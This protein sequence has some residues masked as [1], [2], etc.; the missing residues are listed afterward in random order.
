M[1]ASHKP[2]G[3][4]TSQRLIGLLALGLLAAGC[5]H[6]TQLPNLSAD[7]LMQRGMDAYARHKWT[8]AVEA[9]EQFTLQYPQN[10]RHQ[11]ARFRLAEAYIGKKEYITAATELGKLATDYPAGNYADDA[12]LKIC[13]AYYKM[14]PKS[15]LDQQYTRAAVDHCQALEAYYPNS[16]YVAAANRM[17]KEMIDKLAN[18]DYRAA[19]YYFK[20]GAVDSAILYYESTLNE[21]P[22]SASAPLSLLR[23]YQAYTNLG[24]KEEADGAKARLLKDYPDSDAART[25]KGLT[26]AKTDTT[27]VK[28]KTAARDTLFRS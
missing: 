20:R 10:P 14:S 26:A 7:Q 9:F 18:K 1:Q 16:E 12:R 5:S 3:Y 27:A 28:E 4:M 19:E 24:Y 8:A 15:Q 17:A 21:Y 25:M 2:I 11:E 22:T 23:L 13:E 6:Q